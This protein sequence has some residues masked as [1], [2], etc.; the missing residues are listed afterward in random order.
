VLYLDFENEKDAQAVSALAADQNIVDPEE[1]ENY[2]VEIGGSGG[3]QVR[4]W[5]D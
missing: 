2:V 1:D 4:L 5:W 3:W